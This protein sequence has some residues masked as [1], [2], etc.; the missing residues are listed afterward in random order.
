MAKSKPRTLSK[1]QREEQ[2]QTRRLMLMGGGAAALV[3]AA[4][5]GVTFLPPSFPEIKGEGTMRERLRAEGI[6]GHVMRLTPKAKTDDLLVIGTTDC[7]FCRQFISDG[8]EDTIA[9]A[10]ENGLGLVY[11]AT[12]SSETSLAS[13]QLTQCIGA[14]GKGSAEVLQG[15]YDAAPYLGVEGALKEAAEDLGRKAGLTKTQIRNCV[16]E[17]PV[18]VTRR[19]QA[20]NRAFPVR[21]TPMFSIA[22]EADSEKIVWFSGWSGKSGL[23]RQALAARGV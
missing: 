9:F 8:L 6:E 14:A 7:T 21:G 15:I 22:T 4:G 2:R 18:E 19:I 3:A 11:A 23:R 17:E 20:L 12:G 10:K 16:D 13:S 1:R 5:V